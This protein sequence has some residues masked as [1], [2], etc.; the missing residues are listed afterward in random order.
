MFCKAALWLNP[1]ESFA[2]KVGNKKYTRNIASKT[3]KLSLKQ[4]KL[5]KTKKPVKL[6]SGEKKTRIQVDNTKNH[7]VLISQS[8]GHLSTHV[9]KNFSK[10]STYTGNLI[11]VAKKVS[12]PSW[13]G[14]PSQTIQ[15]FLSCI[16][17]HDAST[18]IIWVRRERE[19]L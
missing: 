9:S 11:H 14:N 12:I 16:H 4:N 2:N 3:N 10:H 13:Y 1:I 17:H 7:Y 18:R 5:Q 8:K 15:H 19:T 6:L